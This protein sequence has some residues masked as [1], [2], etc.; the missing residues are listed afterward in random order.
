MANKKKRSGK[1]PKKSV[2]EHGEPDSGE[3]NPSVPEPD[4]D[5][6]TE[7]AAKTGDISLSPAPVLPSPVAGIGSAGPNSLARSFSF[8]LLLA[9]IGLIGLLSYRV[10]RSFLLPLFLAALLVVIFRPVHEWIQKRC[11]N[12]KSL[13]A[14][15]TT[16][17]ILVV[18]LGPVA[19]TVVAG[20][21][22]GIELTTD[23]N[24]KSDIGKLSAAREKLGLDMPVGEDLAEIQAQLQS[25]E[26]SVDRTGAA[27]EV[28]QKLELVSAIEDQLRQ[29]KLDLP[30]EA[31]PKEKHESLA[32][33]IDRALPLLDR[34]DEPLQK[35]KTL[36][37][38]SQAD[39]AEWAEIDEYEKLVDLM[40]DR[41]TAARQSL[42][43]GVVWAPIVELVNPSEERIDQWQEYAAGKLRSWMLKLSGQTTSIMGGLLMQLF[44]FTISTFYFLVDGPQMVSS[45]M[46]LSPMEDK[47]EEEIISEFA[48]LSRAVVV[49]TLLSAIVQG[50]LAGIGYFAVWGFDSLFMLIMLTSILAMIPFVGAAAVWVPAC[51]YLA[52]IENRIPAAIGLAVYGALIVSMA[53]NVIKP[54]VLKGQSNLHPL[55]ALLSVLGGVQALGPIGV[56]VGPMVVAFLQSLLKILHKEMHSEEQAIVV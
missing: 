54:M 39:G 24:W 14:G 12:R 15:L 28:P 16:A 36:V 19:W 9:I 23:R 30:G 6:E 10:M 40:S 11:G 46:R 45:A 26:L 13:A 42:M 21:R 20:V 7:S 56:L 41:Y 49:A 27:A 52:F 55:F 8:V 53:D 5:I 2:S 44:I 37:A 22:E 29:F 17:A 48:K 35:L 34:M 51:I 25:L 1:K 18:A 31:E 3:T 4:A 47:H 33:R 50:L 32:E 38:E 43:G